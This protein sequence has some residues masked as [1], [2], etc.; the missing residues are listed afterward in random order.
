MGSYPAYR[1]FFFLL[2]V[3]KGVIYGVFIMLGTFL[4]L[5]SSSWF[6]VWI[7]LEMNIIGFIPLVGVSGMVRSESIFKYFLIQVVGSIMLFLVGLV[8]RFHFGYGIFGYDLF[9]RG[10]AIIFIMA[11][12]AGARPF[13]HWFVSVREGLDWVRLRVLITW[14]KLIPLGLVFESGW[15]AISVVI[16]G[17]FRVVVGGLGGFN[18]IIIKKLLAYS[19][20]SHLGWIIILFMISWWGG[21]IY[22]ILYVFVTLGVVYYFLGRRFYHIG[23][24]FRSSRTRWMSFGGFCVRLFSLGGLPPFLGFF[25]K[26]LGLILII[27]GGY[28]VVGFIFM[29]VGLITLYYYL[30]MGYMWMLGGV[31]GGIWGFVGGPR[32]YFLGAIMGCVTVFVLPVFIWLM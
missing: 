19:S 31:D 29:V 28:V 11:L 26:W 5:R 23:Q 22:F 18:E 25:P 1:L 10:W 16:I 2:W 8:G 30:R 24:L 21:I 6:V 4:T 13:H 17:V 20:I 3:I 9:L 27:R 32:V 7:G 14:Q 15:S 12:R